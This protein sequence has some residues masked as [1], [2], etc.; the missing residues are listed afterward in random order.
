VNARATA[1]NKNAIA[2]AVPLAVTRWA[3]ADGAG[4][5][6]VI[7]TGGASRRR[8]ALGPGNFPPVDE[9]PPVDDEPPVAEGEPPALPPV[10]AM[11]PVPLRMARKS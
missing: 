9:V 7:A 6:R 10:L 2:P 3:L 4:A 1:P 11:S 8:A 5:T